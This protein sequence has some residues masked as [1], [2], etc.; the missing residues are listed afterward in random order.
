MDELDVLRKNL[1]KRKSSNSGTFVLAIAF[2]VMGV[3]GFF[4]D[5]INKLGTPD[6]THIMLVTGIAIL[7]TSFT[8]KKE[9]AEEQKALEGIAGELE[10]T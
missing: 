7:V 4:S 3:S 1:K 8:S 6:Y 10:K 9:A 5:F 2:I